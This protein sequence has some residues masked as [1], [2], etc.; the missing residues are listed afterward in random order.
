MRRLAALPV[1]GR[2]TVAGGI[3]L[4][5]LLVV[6]NGGHA[7]WGDFKVPT[8][9]PVFSDLRSLT[10][11][12]E[13]AREGLNPLSSN[14]CDPYER[15]ANYPRLWWEGLAW[16]GLGESSTIAIGLLAGAA[17]LACVL[18]L[19]P[20]RTTLPAAGVWVAAIVSPAVML[21]IERGNPDLFLFVILVFALATF[22][23]S[24]L[25]RV[26]SAALVVEAAIL[27]LFP[28][29]A[30]GLLARQRRRRALAT[31]AAAL[32]VLA[33][34][35][36][37]TYDDIRFIMEVVPKFVF[38]SFGAEVGLHAIRDGLE[39]PDSGAWTA[40]RMLGIAALAAIAAAFAWTRR[41]RAGPPSLPSRGGTLALDAYWMGALV[42]AGSFASSYN[43]D[44]RLMF[45][46]LTLP[47]LLRWARDPDPPLPGARL[48]LAALVGTLWLSEILSGWNPAYPFE[49]VLN[50][51]LF[52]YLL[53]GVLVTLPRWLVA[54]AA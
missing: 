45:L 36:V 14:P 49:E 52:G 13:C 24:G 28:V 23:R 17:F 20:R 44:Y 39:T 30:L 2:W 18:W 50:W 1:P 19:V 3:Y 42:Y 34:Y 7:H 10:T 35:A 5:F 11:A 12:W 4:Y 9:N 43:W 33:V 25:G 54:R 37:A 31:I 53:A 22:R 38:F 6:A 16:L 27:K 48:A 40:A 46:L 15:N 47:Q 21:G 32:A 41:A 8:F 51:A 26:V 29:F